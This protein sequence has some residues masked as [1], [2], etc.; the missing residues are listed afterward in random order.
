MLNLTKLGTLP[1]C[2]PETRLRCF[3]LIPPYYIAD[4]IQDFL[5]NREEIEG[6]PW[7]KIGKL[8]RLVGQNAIIELRGHYAIS[9]P[10]IIEEAAK[11]RILLQKYTKRIQSARSGQEISGIC[12]ELQEEA[13]RNATLHNHTGS[14]EITTTRRITNGDEG[15]NPCLIYNPRNQRMHFLAFYGNDNGKKADLQ[16][17]LTLELCPS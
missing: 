4:G 6:T 13:L 17:R 14:L 15:D 5:E 2:P 8:A 3:F 1:D 11:E 7:Y 16:T 12:Y 9:K 10:D